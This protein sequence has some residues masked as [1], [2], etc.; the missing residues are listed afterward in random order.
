MKWIKPITVI[1]RTC[2][3]SIVTW[4]M[5]LLQLLRNEKNE[6]FN[7]VVLETKNS[8]NYCKFCCWKLRQRREISV[9]QR[10]KIVTL[11]EETYS[12]RPLFKK[13]KF[14]KTVIHQA[15]ARFKMFGSFQDLSTAGRPKV[16]SQRDGHMIKK[17]V[18]FSLTTLSKNIWSDLLLIGA[19]VST[20]T[21]K[22]RFSD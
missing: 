13:H 15:V 19:D 7:M 16:T 5:L 6:L 10:S 4:L 8:Q 14:S 17:M 11:H 2:W 22:C 12:E 9:A 18:A 1:G 3:K 20:S 21:L